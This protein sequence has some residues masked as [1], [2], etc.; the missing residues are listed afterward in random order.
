MRSVT[1]ALVL[2]GILSLIVGVVA[3]VWPGITVTAFVILFAVY[4]FIL[5]LVELMRAFASRSAGPV[6]GRLLLALL[7]AAAG[8]A[9][10]VWPA[11]TAYAL[12]LLVAVW[13]VVTGVFEFALAFSAGR[14]AGDRALYGLTGLVSVA[15]GVVLAI[16][17]DIGA[18]SLAQVYGLFSI[19]SGVSALVL[20]ANAGSAA[21]H[22]AA[23]AG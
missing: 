6:A 21:R 1:G 15:L 18:L 12:V 9:A 23:T 8:V 22:L 11:I 20:A 19:V 2:R 14:T 17:P 16:R 5:A 10:L 3:V 13:A 4:A 7:D